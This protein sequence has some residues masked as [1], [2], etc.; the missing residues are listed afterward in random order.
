MYLRSFSETR[1]A[2]RDQATNAALDLCFRGNFWR[3]R[4]LPLTGLI[5]AAIGERLLLVGSLYVLR[6]E[7]SFA[8]IIQERL[9]RSDGKRAERCLPALLSQRS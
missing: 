7:R 8:K 3:Q 5:S 4:L 2:R 6:V 9:A 1:A